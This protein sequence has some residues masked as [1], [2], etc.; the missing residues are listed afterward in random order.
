MKL[1]IHHLFDI[2]RDFGSG[3]IFEKHDYGHSYHTI[4]QKIRDDKAIEIKLVIAQD[5]ICE[6]CIKLVDGDCIDSINHRKD[7]DKKEVFNNYLD[8]RIMKILNLQEHEVVN[9]EEI[10]KRSD[11]YLDK[12]EYIY[13]GNDENHT[14][15]R[16]SHVIKGV[17]KLKE[18]LQ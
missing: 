1:R 11:S 3:K 2:I 6:N 5:D 14:L 8:N 9:L 15:M 12:I 4:A 17:E 10:V 18:V 7:F 16:K 13:A